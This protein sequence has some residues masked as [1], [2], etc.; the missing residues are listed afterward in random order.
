MIQLRVKMSFFE[1]T[2]L[3]FVYYKQ[4]FVDKQTTM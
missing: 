1:K 3:F 4:F 2:S